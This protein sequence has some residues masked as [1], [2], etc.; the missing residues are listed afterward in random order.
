LIRKIDKPGAPQ[1]PWSLEYSK[2]GHFV[3]T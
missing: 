3:V 2:V 1:H